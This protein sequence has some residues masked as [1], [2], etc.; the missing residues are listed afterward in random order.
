VQV[1]GDTLRIRRDPVLEDMLRGLGAR[2]R[3]L[4]APFDPEHGA[5][6]HAS[7]HDHEH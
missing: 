1:V 2:L 6:G 7:H 5:Y 4:E 3:S